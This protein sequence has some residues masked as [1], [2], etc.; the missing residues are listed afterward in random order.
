VHSVVSWDFALAVLPGWHSTIFPPYFVAGAIHSGLAMVLVLLIPLRK[1]YRFEHI[2]TEGTLE[3]VAKT[4]ILTCAI[5]GYSYATEYFVAWYTQEKA[6]I[7]TFI[8]RAAG[9]YAVWFWLML[10]CNAA[11]PYLFFVRQVRTSTFALFAIAVLV[12]FGMWLERYVIIIG[13]PTHTD[14]PYV[15]RLF[16]GPTW[17]ELGVMFGS[18]C[19]FF[20]FFLLFAKFL[21]TVSIAEVKE[22]AALPAP[23]GKGGAS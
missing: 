17:M 21:P 5:M 2:I 9:H 6:E 10:L 15:W 4:L 12:V 3:N 14:D 7:G 23:A 1:L 16:Q 8:Y 22:E 18:F 11:V 20:F 13:A 19:L